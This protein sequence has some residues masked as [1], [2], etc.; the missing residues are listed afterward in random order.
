MPTQGIDQ[1][2]ELLRVALTLSEVEREALA[3]ELLETVSGKPPGLSLDDPA[4]EE[5]LKRRSEDWEGAVPAE[6][7]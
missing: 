5:E 7:I 2:A 4:F 1:K 6:E 3:Y